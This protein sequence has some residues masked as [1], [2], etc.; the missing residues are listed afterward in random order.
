MQEAYLWSDCS[1]SKYLKQDDINPNGQTV[2]IDSFEKRIIEGRN[3][4]PDKTKLCCKFKEFDKELVLNATNGDAIRL[5]TQSENPI[6]AIGKQIEM[7][8]DRSISFGGKI[9]GGIRF[10]QISA[11]PYS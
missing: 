7:Y 10:R 5:F 2:T 9:V 6:D 8:V 11:I 3:G 4:E 1:D